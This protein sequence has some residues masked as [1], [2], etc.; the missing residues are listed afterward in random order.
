VAAH[1]PTLANLADDYLRAAR[2]AG[3]RPGTEIAY[4]WALKHWLR[5]T[6]ARGVDEPAQITVADVEAFQD[7]LVESGK[8]KQSQRI[9]S[10][11][12][13]EMLK[14]AA[15]KQLVP[16]EL[17]LAV[18][19]VRV[20]RGVPRPVAAEDLKRLLLYL[21]PLKPRMTILEVRDRALA[22]YLLGTS[23]RVS[24]A[25]QVTERD[26]EHAWVIQKG[27]GQQAL[28]SPP[29]VV[30]A[31]RLYLARRGPVASEF[32]WITHDTNRPV[33]RLTPEG[34]RGIFER[35]ARQVGIRHFSPH[36][37]RHSAASV[38]LDR[39]VPVTGIAD[40][41]GHADLSTVMGYAKM[42]PRRRQEAVDGLQGFLEETIAEAQPKGKASATPTATATAA[43][44][45][46]GSTE[47]LV[48]LLL[49]K[50]ERLNNRVMILEDKLAALTMPPDFDQ[51]FTLA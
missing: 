24:E 39:G 14:W 7:F 43:L 33:R 48:N 13:R 8:S 38:L 49:A 5:I 42:S 17:H 4:G 27:G 23:S 6:A 19:K 45:V 22:L 1:P 51:P 21:L 32:V 29:I 3:N 10:T 25:L 9:G 50:V 20:P 35:L 15:A 46:E 36:Q 26:W 18:S 40:H 37:L 11:A 34:A 31:V 44:P 30:E 12:L 28:L 47:E 16:A 41:L 2:R